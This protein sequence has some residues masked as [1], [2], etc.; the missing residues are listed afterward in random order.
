[1]YSNAISWN[2]KLV[3]RCLITHFLSV[4]YLLQT[5][6]LHLTSF[7]FLL[8]SLSSM[9][10]F[11]HLFQFL[12]LLL[13]F[14]FL[15]PPSPPSFISSTF[16]C[17]SFFFLLYI[18]Y[19]RPRYKHHTSAYTLSTLTWQTSPAPSLPT[20]H[21]IVCLKREKKMRKYV[22]SCLF[23]WC[24]SWR[25]YKGRGPVPYRST[26]GSEAEWAEPIWWAEYT[27]DATSWSHLGLTE[28]VFVF[29]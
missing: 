8:T 23:R 13:L 12:S 29:L 26:A 24:K 22:N 11:Q 3:I 20:V 4:S 27:C 6:L 25:K 28:C 5:L 9:I 16:S 19:W 7:F 10:S 1:M 14:F 2:Y 15:P 17:F 21:V 18:V